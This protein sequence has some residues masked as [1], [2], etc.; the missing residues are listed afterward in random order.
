M[1]LAA[2]SQCINTCLLRCVNARF[3]LRCPD[4]Q[5]PRGKV[6]VLKTGP[7]ARDSLADDTVIAILQDL[8]AQLR[9]GDWG[10]AVRG[11]PREG[12]RSTIAQEAGANS[13]TSEI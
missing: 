9:G 10:P 5:R 8:R 13:R 7:G 11:P 12:E 6:A 4:I 3:V 2:P 1:A